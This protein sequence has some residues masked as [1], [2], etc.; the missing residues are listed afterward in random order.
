VNRNGDE[1]DEDE[2]WDHID[3][4]KDLDLDAAARALGLK[5][6][7][8]SA[9]AT[10][11]GRRTKQQQRHPYQPEKLKDTVVNAPQSSSSLSLW[12]ESPSTGSRSQVSLVTSATTTATR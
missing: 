12:T 1:E 6:V 3:S 11:R 5:D 7:N 4:A 9:L 8:S 2:D 10:V